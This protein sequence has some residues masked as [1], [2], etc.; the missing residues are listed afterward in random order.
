MSRGQGGRRVGP[1]ATAATPRPRHSADAEKPTI[2]ASAQSQ[3][4]TLGDAA[5]E[6]LLV[7]HRGLSERLLAGTREVRHWAALDRK[8]RACENK[9]R[10]TTAASHVRNSRDVVCDGGDG[11]P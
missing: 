7:A 9:K 8:P 2:W 4:P 1:G 5:A 11:Q 6:R 10:T 3:L